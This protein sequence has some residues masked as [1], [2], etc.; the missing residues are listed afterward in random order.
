MSEDLPQI[1][2]TES[3]ELT[4]NTN[5]YSWKIKLR[6]EAITFKTLERLES[7]NKN[8]IGRFSYD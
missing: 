5:G 8:L 1:E 6:D 2:P 4:K 7:L 3:I